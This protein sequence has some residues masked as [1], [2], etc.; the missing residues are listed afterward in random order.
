MI[1]LGD[2]LPDAQL[3]R[4]GRSGPEEVSLSELAESRRIVLVTV[5][6]AFTPTCDAQHLPSFVRTK[7]S[8]GPGVTSSG[9]CALRHRIARP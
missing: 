6:G 1:T 5:P 9:R 2:T 4:M 8:F 7:P 3:I